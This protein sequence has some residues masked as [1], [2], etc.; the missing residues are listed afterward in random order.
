MY[1][2]FVFDIDGTLIDTERTGVLSL[3][4]T[5]K[6][7]LGLEMSYGEAYGYF[8]IPSA[9][10][11][12]LLG[13][14]D[15]ARFGARWE[16]NFVE[17]SHM[18]RA[19]DGVEEVLASVRSAGRTTGCVTSRSRYEFEKDVHMQR[20]VQY[21]DHIVCAE[22]SPLHKP[23]PDPMLTFMR[24]AAVGAL[25]SSTPTDPHKA[26]SVAGA[27]VDPAECI[28]IGDT[29]HDFQCAAGAGCDFALADWQGR[30]LQGIPA[31]YHL[32]SVPQILDLL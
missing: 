4:Q 31:R 10:V 28:Y 30:G 27:L 14:A 29:L 19:F 3:M 23:H 22:D 9:K 20:L 16:E 13:Y 17:L 5:V 8:G 26:S 25:S 18:M 21:F 11:A 24:K 15:A 32:T 6:E 2:Y 7:L 1:R 12:P